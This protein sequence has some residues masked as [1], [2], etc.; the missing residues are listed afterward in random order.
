MAIQQQTADPI[1]IYYQMTT[2]NTSFIDMHHY[3]RYKGIKNNKFFLVLY[4]PDL[5]GV[6]PR[7]PNLSIMMKRKILRECVVNYWYFIREVVRIPDQGGTVG[8]G[9]RYR[10]HRGNLALNFGFLMNWNMFLELPRQHYKTISS[11][12]WYLWCYNF[13]TTNSEIM[14]MNKRHDDSKMNLRRLREIRDALPPYLQMKE[15]VD[16]TGKKVVGSKNVESAQN[17]INH[18]KITTKPSARSKSLAN[19]LG[20]G[21]TMP[22]HWYDEYAFIPFNNIIYSAATPAYKTASMNAKRNGAPYG[23]L[24]TTTPGDTTTDEGLNA[25]NT[26]DQATPFNESF[27]DFTMEELEELKNSNTSSSFFYIKFTYRQL[28]SGEQYFKEMVIDLQKDWTAIRR[29]VLLEWAKCS[30]NSPFTQQDLEIIESLVMKEPKLQLR[31]C[32]YYFMNIYKQTDI[33]KYPPIIGV[34]V[35]GGYQKDSSTI[36]II[37]SKTTEVIADFNCNYISIRDLANVIYELVTKYM[38]NAVVN[39]ERNGGFG[40]SVLSILLKTRIKRNLYFEI[41]DRVTEERYD[42]IRIVKKTQKVKV[43]GFDETKASRE[44]LMEILRDRVDNHKGKFISPII[45]NELTTLEVKKNGKIEH[46]NNAHD[47][48]IFSYLMALYV[49]YEGQNLMENFGLEKSVIR[50]DEDEDFDGDGLIEKYEDISIKLEED[51]N[52]SII[53]PQLNYIK[54]DNSMSYM[55]WL[56]SEHENDEKAMA[57]LLNTKL[58]RKAYSR[59]FH[60]DEEDIGSK[61]LFRIPDTIF[62]IDEPTKKKTEMQEIFESMIDP[63]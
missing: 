46:S 19:S 5:D 39:I 63:R 17:V 31:L 54:S 15:Y 28:G 56:I 44:K 9:V 20:R 47:D 32:N 13:G 4:D 6:D 34:D 58:G 33:Y 26:K 57:D 43:Y 22:M 2:T 41:K 25:L 18:N 12:C 52:D 48:Q 49:W 36:T 3:L 37:D 55:D 59:T 27:Y 1:R 16:S 30:D 29:E 7:D 14:F 61:A 53:Q 11:I 8:S 21:C 23:I 24:I 38:P 42:G 60:I 10:L 50:T 45:Y 35:S 51:T 62:M 40:A